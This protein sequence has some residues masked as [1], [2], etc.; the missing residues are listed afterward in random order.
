M[1]EIMLFG[2]GGIILILL[3]WGA[4]KMDDAEDRKKKQRYQNRN[5]E[6]F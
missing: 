5:S 6:E 1:L 3:G 4:K 2:I